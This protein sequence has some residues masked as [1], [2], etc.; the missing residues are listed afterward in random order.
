MAREAGCGTE[1]ERDGV[2]NPIL[3]YWGDP[4]NVA[5][6]PVGFLAFGRMVLHLIVGYFSP[7]RARNTQQSIIKY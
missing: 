7:R 5:T 2:A 1:F 3:G 4:V 6:Y